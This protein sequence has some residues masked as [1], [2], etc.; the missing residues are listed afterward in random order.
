MKPQSLHAHLSCSA[1]LVFVVAVL[2]NQVAAQTAPFPVYV[3]TGA[4]QQIL[5]IDGNSGAVTGVC[6]I[7]AVPEDVV[8]GPDGNLYV[9]DTSGNKIYRVTTP[10]APPA[11]PA[12][13]CD[14][15][16]IYDQSVTPS[17]CT[18][19]A[20]QTGQACPTGPEGP[21]FLRISTLD[22][23]FNTH[24]AG[25][26]GVWKIPCAA[27]STDIIKCPASNPPAVQVLSDTSIGSGE[28]VD[29]DIF[30]KVLAVDQAGNKVLRKCLASA[31]CSPS[32]VTAISTGLSAPVGIALNTCGDILVASGNSIRRYNNTSPTATFQDSLS[33][34]GNNTPRFFE[35]DSSNR[36]FVVTASDESGK[37]G[38]F[39][40]FD[41]PPPA[42]N[43]PTN[44]LRSCG[45]GS[46]TTGLTVP[47]KTNLAAGIATSN[48]LGLGLSASN[49]S[50]TASFDAPT[51][52]HPFANRNTYDFGAQH[53]F[54]VTCN[55]VNSAFDLT[56]TAV[57][58]QPTDTANAE[59]TFTPP[60][61]QIPSLQCPVV[62]DQPQCL[63]YGGQH[64]FC[65]Q[66]VETSS[67]NVDNHCAVSQS[68]QFTFFV[69]FA[70][71]ESIGNPGGAHTLGQNT[72]YPSS[73]PFNEC[74]SKDFYDALAGADP[75]RM[76]GSNSKHVVFNANQSGGSITLNSP[77][78][79][80]GSLAN[81]NPQFNIG[82]N[83]NV[84]FTLLQ[85]TTPITDATEQLSIARVRNTYK[86]VVTD[87]FVPQ[88]VVS[89]KASNVLNFFNPNSSG[90]YS[91]NDNSSAFDKLPKG[92]TAVYQY[93][94]WG[95]GAPPKSFLVSGTF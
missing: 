32:P 81:C 85:G 30:G 49:V 25:S 73:D 37:G 3:S 78:S 27:N 18:N 19:V 76:S 21:S 17:S 8:V 33:F 44:P 10:I 94:I 14:K 29:F 54:T 23:Y 39:W 82:Q 80:C 42:G 74:Q 59:V 7:P 66:Y 77:I 51:Q 24:G 4:G 45:L 75:V 48:A 92:T 58:S 57:K 1:I 61:P 34:S 55:K 52:Q 91:Y 9:A 38:T 71:A 40:R 67:D 64:G 50:I 46:F 2:C 84:K 86:G 60:F 62:L 16:A 83:V 93:T 69:T 70:A 88:T 28:G 13:A 87:E 90:Q 56:V 72:T 35:V 79:S 47:I 26:S 6:N 36:L 43:P 89:T 41:P 5:A 53:T 20:G 65:T 12:G 68:G 22:L 11:S 95:N 15:T 63:H 31:G